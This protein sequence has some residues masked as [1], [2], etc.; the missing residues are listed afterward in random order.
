MLERIREGSQG[1]WA[2]IIIG[3]VVLSF[4]FAGVGSYLNSSGTTT[5]ATVNGT[6]IDQTTLERAYQN[7]RA[8]MESEYGESVAAMFT[9]TDREKSTLALTDRRAG[10]LFNNNG[11]IN[12]REIGPI[13]TSTRFDKMKKDKIE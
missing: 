7:Q 8:R 3:L 5:V 9:L 11:K 1:P 6:E 12:Q 10:C 2:M 13:S 4:V